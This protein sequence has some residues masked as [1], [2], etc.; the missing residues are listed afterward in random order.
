MTAQQER[1]I[2]TREKVIAGA[3]EVFYRQGFGGA[4]LSDITAAAGVTKGAL[5]F[6]FP[7]KE[8]VAFAII[9]AEHQIATA[10]AARILESTAGP[11]ESMLRLCADLAERLT[12]D[13]IVRAGIRLTTE[14]SSFDRSLTRPY[15]D[16]L[17][18]FEAL[19]RAATATGELRAGTDAAKL[20]HFIIP[21]F[22]GVQMVSDVFTER[23]DLRQR[24]REMWEILLPALVPPGDES[25]SQRMLEA[26][27]SPR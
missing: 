7:S 16:W 22:T 2:L 4:T 11:L 24:V 14:T 6:H 27:F 21:A 18:T 9:E 3:A 8:D 13:P 17:A 20:A 25:S 23:A 10:A 1:A 15:E 12:T 26:A 19:A 5:Y